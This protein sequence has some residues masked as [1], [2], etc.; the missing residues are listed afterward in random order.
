MNSDWEE[1]EMKAT[2]A[3]LVAV[4]AVGSVSYAQ[5]P[6]PPGSPSGPIP[7]AQGGIVWY[8]SLR[9]GVAEAKRTNRPIL[10]ISAAPH[11]HNVS[12]IW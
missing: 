12:G 5:R 10:L 9:Q 8:G 2:G 1:I 6:G 7:S 11:C 3:L 4:M